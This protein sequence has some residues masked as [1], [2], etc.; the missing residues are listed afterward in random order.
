MNHVKMIVGAAAMIFAVPALAALPPQYQRAAE[1]KAIIDNDDIPAAF[2]GGTPIDRVEYV[3]NDLY[4][5]TAGKCSLEVKIV[6]QP[7]PEGLV[8]PRRFELSVGKVE[9][10]AD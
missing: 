1:L 10:A 4:R 8:G 6:D 7:M 2:P 9:C 3:S 5:V